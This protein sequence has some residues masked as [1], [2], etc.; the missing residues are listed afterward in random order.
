MSEGV[1]GFSCV[2]EWGVFFVGEVCMGWVVAVLS[3]CGRVGSSFE[4]LMLRLSGGVSMV[5]VQGAWEAVVP[6]QG[7]GSIVGLGWASGGLICVG[8]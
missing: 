2:G 4:G 1:G 8:L 7:G 5:P 6:A 3:E